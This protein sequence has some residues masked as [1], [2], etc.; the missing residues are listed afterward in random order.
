[1]LSCTRAGHVPTSHVCV[2]I[3]SFVP[4]QSQLQLEQRGEEEE[5]AASRKVAE[6]QQVQGVAH[7]PDLPSHAP[8]TGVVF[9]SPP[10]NV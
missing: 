2:F 4:C 8:L 5:F 1:M 6:E 7:C 3:H 9:R 10:D